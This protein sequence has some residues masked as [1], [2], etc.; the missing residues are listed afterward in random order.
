MKRREFI[1]TAAATALVAGSTQARAAGDQVT[2]H[3]YGADNCPPCLAFKRNHLANVQAQG[4]T[5]GFAV[6]VNMTARIRDVPKVGTYGDRDPILRVAAEELRIVYPPI[7]FVSRGG[8]VVSVHAH[9]WAAAL[10]A[11]VELTG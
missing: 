10:Q 2:F 7:F 8:E 6:E 3:F 9:D 11:A 5:H 1:A 4:A